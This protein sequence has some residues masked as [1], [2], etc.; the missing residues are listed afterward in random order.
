L[1]LRPYTHAPDSDSLWHLNSGNRYLGLEA[2]R[3]LR[4]RRSLKSPLR[5]VAVAPVCLAF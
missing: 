3:R 4:Y 1:V 5:S 2:S